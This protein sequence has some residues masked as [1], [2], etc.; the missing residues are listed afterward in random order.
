MKKAHFIKKSLLIIFVFFNINLQATVKFDSSYYQVDVS[1]VGTSV[2]KQASQLAELLAELPDEKTGL[3]GLSLRLEHRDGN[4]YKDERIALEMEFFSDGLRDAWVLLDKERLDQRFQQQTLNSQLWKSQLQEDLQQVINAQA[5]INKRMLDKKNA[6]FARM[7]G[8]KQQQLKKG[9]I[10]RS[11]LLAVQ[12]ELKQVRLEQ[13]FMSLQDIPLLPEQW[14]IKLN[15]IEDFHLASVV[16]LKQYAQKQSTQ[17]KLLAIRQA[18]LDIK[19][20]YLDD[21]SLKLFVE[22]RNDPSVAL[23]NENLIG[24]QL[25][26]PLSF[27]SKTEDKQH[28]AKMQLDLQEKS[29]QRLLNNTISRLHNAFWKQRSELG[30]LQL[31]YESLEQERLLVLRQFGATMTALNYQPVQ[32]TNELEL[33]KIE[34]EKQIL[35]ARLMV[36]SC[37]IQLQSLLETNNLE[38]L[39]QT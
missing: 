2:V 17:L 18:Q 7:F 20:S 29:A 3:P 33:E 27:D 12:T 32:R 9:V 8:Q 6:Y 21:V 16:F 26:L 30:V 25:K 19:S 31:K 38:E 15:N 5:L 13:Q 39:E 14:V 4:G 37:L 1:E 10:E 28:L 11:Q 22:N 36:F 35:N 23:L 34:L 24:L